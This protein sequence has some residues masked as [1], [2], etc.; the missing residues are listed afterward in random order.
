M[1]VAAK[2]ISKLSPMIQEAKNRGADLIEVRLDYLE[3]VEGIQKI[4]EDVSIP[5]VAT[6]RKYEQGG[7]RIQDEENR[8]SNLVRAAEVGFEYAD[9]E[10]TTKGVEDIVSELKD[11]GVRPII[12]FHELTCTPS[13]SEMKKIVENQIKADAEVCKLVTTAKNVEDNIPCLL[14]ASQ[15]SNVTKIVCFAMGDKGLISRVFSPL[16]GAYFTYASIR[17]G[18]ETAS[19]QITISEFKK[20]CSTLG[21][22]I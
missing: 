15:M 2:S 7:H 20:I 10:L 1:P 14:L 18:M 22:D 3:S 11:M 19:G 5:L 16:F 6:N 12:S 13:L 17:K 8:I 4:V 21:V 9:I